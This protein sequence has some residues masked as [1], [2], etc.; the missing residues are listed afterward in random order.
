MTRGALK[1]VVVAS[2]KSGTTWVQRLISAHPAMHCGESGSMT[3]GLPATPVAASTQASL[4]EVSPSTVIRLKL[5]ST[6]AAS[7]RCS[8]SGAT[9][10][11]VAR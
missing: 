1:F 2:P 11:S 3:R 8:K 6:A 5:L 7:M 9:V 10:I 4:V